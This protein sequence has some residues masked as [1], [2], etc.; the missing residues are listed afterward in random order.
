MIRTLTVVIA[1]CGVVATCP[2][3]A[4][5]HAI[6]WQVENPFRFF[7]DPADTESHQM[8]IARAGSILDA[9]RLLATR[10]QY[11]W[12]EQTF[13]RTCWDLARQ[14]HSACGG[15]RAYVRPRSH[16]ISARLTGE[17]RRGARCVWQFKTGG[18][19]RGAWRGKTTSCGDAIKLS[20]PYP[21]GGR[22][23]VSIDGGATAEATIRVADLFIVGLGDSY[24]SGEGN[25]DRPV[26]W[27]DDAT[28]SFG[29][30][31]GL[32]LSGYP[33][34]RST[35]VAYRGRRFVGRGAFWLSQ[36]CHRSLYSYQ[37]R[38][39]LQLAL[40]DAHRAVTFLGLSCSGAEITSGLL[41]AWKGV[42]R[43]P[44]VPRRSQVGQ[45]AVAQCGGRGFDVRN[46]ASS[47]TDGGRVPSLDGLAIE[48]CPPEQAREI[49][50]VL[51]SIGGNDIGFA[52][53]VANAI[54]PAGSPLRR[55][56][57][58]TEQVFTARDARRGFPELASRFK[59]LRRAI[60][61]HLHISWDEPYRIILAAYPTIAVERDGKSICNGRTA[62]G[63]DGFPGYR[64]SVR[65]AA[66][67]E[68]VSAELNRRLR[69]VAKRYGWSFVSEHRERFAGRG[70][71]A[72]YE[73][74]PAK[75]HDELLL[76][77]WTGRSWHP[78]P[79]STYRPYAPRLRWMR[80]SND[81]FMTAH[82]DLS[83]DLRRRIRRSRYQ[84]TDL[85]KAST[86]GGAFHPT[87]EGQAA[88][89]DAV[90][91]VARRIIRRREVE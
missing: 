13:K 32:D 88:I 28:A 87:A 20:V 90:V 6:E 60:H 74:E 81:A 40:E 39:A 4:T 41:S 38:V 45:V 19:Q 49:D 67:A 7:A 84:P 21:N 31:R 76:P 9:E 11:G 36:P 14:D 52:K 61:N 5:E 53:L 59:L 89:A 44:S 42:E 12:A 43:F 23:T 3:R 75:R 37:L 1:L 77:R 22:L 34:R 68:A 35:S 8:A 2:A 30:I 54:L 56:S 79:P 64:L 24:A 27:R 73:N 25:P 72:G 16:R 17:A 62:A 26:R 85:L 80:T 33:Q 86:F 15:L 63:L 66:E 69:R 65:R 71:C 48:R 58:L 50:L 29:S 10:T 83:S 57:Q 46:Y 55:L 51:V 47:F 91:S 78:Y 70:I 18:R 82:V